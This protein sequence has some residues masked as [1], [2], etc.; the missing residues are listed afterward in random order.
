MGIWILL[1]L[2]QHFE[3]ATLATD[4]KSGNPVLAADLNGDGRADMR[5]LGER[6][7]I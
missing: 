7:R 2:A 4:L 1:M 3:S 5:A 6:R